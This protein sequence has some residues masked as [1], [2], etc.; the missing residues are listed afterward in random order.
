MGG[1]RGSS[2]GRSGMIEADEM[3]SQSSLDSA[4]IQFFRT[5]IRAILNY[6]ID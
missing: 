2:G 6:S 3:F 4:N 1:R 5:W